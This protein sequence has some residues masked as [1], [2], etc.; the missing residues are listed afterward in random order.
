M[1]KFMTHIN[2]VS[3]LDNS[4]FKFNLL[5]EQKMFTGGFDLNNYYSGTVLL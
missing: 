5:Y 4:I 2:Q 1:T 3:L